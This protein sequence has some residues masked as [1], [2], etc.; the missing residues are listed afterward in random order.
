ME[1]A[2]DQSGC[3]GCTGDA[4]EWSEQGKEARTQIMIIADGTQTL[5][6]SGY[7]EREHGEQ[8]LWHLG[9]AETWGWSRM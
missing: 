7:T 5:L 3:T 2:L 4:G 1:A 8:D 6:V 9:A